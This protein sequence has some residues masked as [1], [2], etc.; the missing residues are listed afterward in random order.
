MS[1]SDSDIASAAM[2]VAQEYDAEIILYNGPIDENGYG[3]LVDL[4]PVMSGKRVILVL[5]TNGGYIKSAYRIG[6]L[7]QTA[8]SEF[9]LFPPG[10]CKSAGTIIALGAN[11]LIAWQLSEF[12]PIDAQ[13]LKRNE[14]GERKSGLLAHSSFEAL[15]R[16]IFSLFEHFILEIRNKSGGLITFDTSS[17][18]GAE[19][20]RTVFSSVY[21]KLDADVLGEEYRDLMVGY[22]YGRR[23]AHWGGNSDEEK[24]KILTN[25]YPSHDFLIDF[26][27]AEEL[28]YEVEEPK[29]SLYKL[30]EALDALAVEELADACVWHLSDPAPTVHPGLEGHGSPEETE[31]SNGERESPGGGSPEERRAERDG[32]EG[33]GS[34]PR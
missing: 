30:V 1:F 19:V 22:E 25:Y 6:R 12:G 24:V 32:M 3:Q 8:P 21:A 29:P 27:E 9:I 20:A 26:K 33:S 2:E 23:L 4:I 13:M 14:L 15:N 11:R 10:F 34:I 17:R 28:F 31:E 7:M 18:I 16:E 5:L